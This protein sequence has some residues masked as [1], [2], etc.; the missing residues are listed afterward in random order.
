[1]S[2]SKT[3]IIKNDENFLKDFSKDFY[4]RLIDI[5][6][7]NTYEVT[8]IEFINNI[9]ENVKKILELM[10]NHK[11]NEFW[12][13]SIIG[14]FYQ[15]GIG[16][17]I[18]KNKALEFYLLSVNNKFEK[19]FINQNFINI[20]KENN[21]EFDIL[22]DINVNIGKYLLSLFYYKDIILNKID[23]INL[24]EFIVEYLRSAKKGDL[25]AQYN[26]GNCYQYGHGV[27]QDYKKA[28][29]WYSY[30]ANNGHAKSQNKLGELYYHGRG[31]YQD[32]KKAFEWYSKS[33]NNGCAEGQNN[34]G[35]CYCHGTGIKQ[36]YK[37]AFKC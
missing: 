29:K 6:D 14:F 22:K 34:L 13:S 11:E 30:S 24:S 12:F 3:K 7:L 15:C 18:D 2:N 28:F 9:D 10:Q 35:K 26:L 27:A 1:M 4:L 5:E 17:I 31:I 16:C 19:E 21:N 32:F 33:A 8:L 20:L 37:K 36:D 23:T 25:I